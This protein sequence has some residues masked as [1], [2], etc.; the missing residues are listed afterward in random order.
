MFSGFPVLAQ[1]LHNLNITCH[2][3][4]I[5]PLPHSFMHLMATPNICSVRALETQVRLS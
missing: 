1:T 2:S 5:H 4:D 3:Q